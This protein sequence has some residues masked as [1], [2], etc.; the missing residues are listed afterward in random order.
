MELSTRFLTYHELKFEASGKYQD[1]HIKRH[2]QL[3]PVKSQNVQQENQR[4]HLLGQ[5][6]LQNLRHPATSAHSWRYQTWFQNCSTPNGNKDSFICIKIYSTGTIEVHRSTHRKE[7][8]IMSNTCRLRESCPLLKSM[9][10]E[11]HL[12]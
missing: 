11:V 6:G 9:I 4:S 3:K 10:T 5:T 1:L 7:C 2:E 12:V 8:K